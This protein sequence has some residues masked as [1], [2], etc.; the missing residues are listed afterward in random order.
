MFPFLNIPLY[1]KINDLSTPTFLSHISPTV[2]YITLKND[3]FLR[4][5]N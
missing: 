2:A 3:F 4:Q 1:F 5:Q